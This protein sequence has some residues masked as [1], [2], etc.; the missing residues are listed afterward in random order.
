V[1]AAYDGHNGA[2]P[3]AP[4]GQEL[5][6][7]L[8]AGLRVCGGLPPREGLGVGAG[9]DVW[10]G[11]VGDGVGCGEVGEGDGVGAGEVG[12]GVGLELG[13]DDEGSGV[14]DADVGLG[15]G[16][17]VADGAA[18]AAGQIATIPATSR[19]GSTARR[20]RAL[21]RGLAAT[22]VGRRN[23]ALEM[24]ALRPDRPACTSM[25]EPLQGD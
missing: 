2:G 10:A 9:A 14:G 18:V 19:P 1:R 6:E 3:G 11:D 5:G 25:G 23:L 7:G 22:N 20:T 12:E 21:Q 15:L 8:G 4:A 24:M 16:D 13:D 17:G